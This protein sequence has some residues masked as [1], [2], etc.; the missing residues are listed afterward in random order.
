M[1]INGLIIQACRDE[2]LSQE[3]QNRE[4]STKAIGITAFSITAF[5]LAQIF[6]DKKIDEI[7]WLLIFAMAIAMSIVIIAAV[8]I[9]ITKNW[10]RP[11]DVEEVRLAAEEYKD[12]DIEASLGETYSKAIQNNWDILDQKATYLNVLIFSAA[13]QLIFYAALFVYLFFPG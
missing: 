7:A 4:F 8:L 5:S 9:L 11:F 13:V 2:S 12:D 3:W 1:E 6:A 10:E